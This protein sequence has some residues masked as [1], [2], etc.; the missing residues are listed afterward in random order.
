MQNLENKI[1]YVDKKIPDVTGLVRTS[2]IGE[3][4]KKIPD[5]STSV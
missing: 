1:G 4:E 3:I 2:V 5:M